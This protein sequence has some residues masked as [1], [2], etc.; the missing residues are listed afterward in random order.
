MIQ[1]GVITGNKTIGIGAVEG[2]DGRG[3]AIYSEGSV[4]FKGGVISGNM[5]K[6]YRKGD[7]CYGGVGGAV[8]VAKG[9]SL[10]VQGGRLTNNPDERKEQNPFLLYRKLLFCKVKNSQSVFLVDCSRSYIKSCRQQVWYVKKYNKY[11]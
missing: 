10:F 7:I 9:G 2:F 6:G 4:W 5:A 11:A 8:Y 3:G 1:G